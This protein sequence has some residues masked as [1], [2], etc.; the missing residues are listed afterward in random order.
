[1][2]E[3]IEFLTVNPMGVL[4]TVDGGRPRVRPW[5]FMFAEGSRLWFC[6]SNTK[7]V[8]RQLKESPAVEFCTTSKDMVTVRVSG[9]VRFS[10][11]MEVKKA[12]IAKSE[13]VRSIYK[14]ADNPIFEVFCLDHGKAARSD[15]SGQPPRVVEF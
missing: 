9:E 10:Q 2:K 12:I 3:I 14:T 7:E 13:L 15:F 11:D 1:M 8:F 6:T 5:G 4:A